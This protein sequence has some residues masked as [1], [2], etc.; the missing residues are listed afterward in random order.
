MNLTYLFRCKV[1]WG[2]TDP[3]FWTTYPFSRSTSILYS[4]RLHLFWCG[5]KMSI[6]KL[7]IRSPIIWILIA[8]NPEITVNISMLY[9]MYYVTH[10][11]VLCDPWNEVGGSLCGPYCMIQKQQERTVIPI[12]QFIQIGLTL[13]M[14]SE[15]WRIFPEEEFYHQFISIW[16]L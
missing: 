11:A 10:F 13:H 12:N 15:Y 16:T 1:P 3:S 6:Y 7:W 5:M 2:S 8:T 4:F 14:D 9:Y